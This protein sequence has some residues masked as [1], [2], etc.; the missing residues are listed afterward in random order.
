MRVCIDTNVVVRL[1]GQRAQFLGITHALVSGHFVLIVSNDILLEY[2]EVITRLN[3]A[4]RWRKIEMLFAKIHTL[5][6]NIIRV[7]PQFQ[8]RVI[9]NDPDDNKFVDCAIAAEAEFVVTSDKDFAAL[10]DAGYKPRPISPENF[11]VRLRGE[12]SPAP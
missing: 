2:E 5:H 1:F 3:G 9:A 4:D 7:D 6:R 12:L 8:F 11:I 10:R